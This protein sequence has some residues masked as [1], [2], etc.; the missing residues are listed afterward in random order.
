MYFSS[1]HCDALCFKDP[2]L[3]S[4]TVVVRAEGIDSIFAADN[5]ST[6]LDGVTVSQ[7]RDLFQ[8]FCSVIAMY[9]VFDVAYARRLRK[10]FSFLS[11]YIC[12]LEACKMNTA[13]QRR[14]NVLYS[15]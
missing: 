12:K 15:L 2:K 14:L 13:M 6:I 9:W 8:A 4:P 10:T 1:F 11:S 3:P 5:I 7:P